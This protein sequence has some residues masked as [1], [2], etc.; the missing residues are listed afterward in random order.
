LKVL[1]VMDEL[2]RT[3]KIRAKFTEPG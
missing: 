2:E 3:V 1:E